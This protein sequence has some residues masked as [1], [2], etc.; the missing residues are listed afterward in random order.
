MPNYAV[1][2]IIVKGSKEKIKE[3]FERIEGDNFLNTLFP[4][5]ESENDNW[6][7]WNCDNWGTK[8]DA[9]DTHLE[10]TENEDGTAKIEGG[11]LTAWDAPIDCYLNYLINNDDVSIESAGI[12]VCMD[13]MVYFIDGQTYRLNVS[14]YPEL[15]DKYPKFIVDKFDDYLGEWF[16]ELDNEEEE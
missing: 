9:C 12:D 16:Q 11:F 13:Y 2:E 7:D 14:S 6:Y 10:Y 8:W 4:R 15:K 5:P 3:I 1:N